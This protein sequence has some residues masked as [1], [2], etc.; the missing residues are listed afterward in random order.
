[1]PDEDKIVAV[2]LLTEKELRTYG[3]DLK[4][5]YLLPRDGEFDDLLRRLE[6]RTARR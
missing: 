4:E 6:Q 3:R 2:G 5:I 1:M